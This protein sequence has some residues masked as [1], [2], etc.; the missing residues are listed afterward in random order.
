MKCPKCGYREE[1]RTEQQNRLLWAGAY[2][3]IA[4]HLSEQSGKVITRDHVHCVAKDRFMPRI[5]VEFEGK[6]K[7]YP[8]STTRLG[9]KAF[10]DYLEQVYAWGAEM[11]VYFDH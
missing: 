5:T 11:G 6:S 1:T 7:S 9:K 3:P 10:S 4:Q 8:Q 2:S